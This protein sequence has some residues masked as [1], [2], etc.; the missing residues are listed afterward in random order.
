M[1]DTMLEFLFRTFEDVYQ[2]SKE[3]NSR[4]IWRIDSDINIWI[5]PLR[6]FSQSLI[7]S[8]CE[9]ITLTIWTQD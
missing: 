3:S 5:T 1:I 7:K 4:G 9:L 2:K 8:R 6:S